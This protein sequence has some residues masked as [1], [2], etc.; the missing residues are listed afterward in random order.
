[1]YTEC[2]QISD[3]RQIQ[4]WIKTTLNHQNFRRKMSSDFEIQISQEILA[5][6]KS[7]TAPSFKSYLTFTSS[8]EK[9]QRQKLRNKI[10][11]LKNKNESYTRNSSGSEVTNITNNQ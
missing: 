7:D 3:V 2:I 9:T 8:C 1:M 11:T 10:K 6:S 5:I 4:S